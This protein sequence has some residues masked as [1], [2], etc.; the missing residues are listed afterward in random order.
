MVDIDIGIRWNLSGH[1]LTLQE[2]LQ[3]ESEREQ[4]PDTA[5][6]HPPHR[7]PLPPPPA[8]HAGQAA[9]HRGHAEEV[10]WTSCW[11]LGSNGTFFRLRKYAGPSDLS[12]YSAT[13]RQ[14]IARGVKQ[15]KE[16][17]AAVLA[18]YGR[19]Q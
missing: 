8:P 12:G 2:V 18:R 10:R 19:D 15:V 4:P 14:E 7:P 6:R 11:T 5:V 16:R 3:E 13:E 17:S 1:C 9:K